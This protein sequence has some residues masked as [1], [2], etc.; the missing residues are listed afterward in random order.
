VFSPDGALLAAGGD[1]VRLWDVGALP[2]HAEPL[3]VLN[4]GTRV[5]V[6]NHEG[7]LLATTSGGV[8]RLWGVP[9]GP[10]S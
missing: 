9:A 4:T 1:G 7:T 8:I 3:A 10:S 6:F 2:A 5:V